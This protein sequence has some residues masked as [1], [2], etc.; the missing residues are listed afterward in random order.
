ML[1]KI[2]KIA[3]V[4]LLFFIVL[5]K[6]SNSF[7]G[8][9][10]W[11]LR[12]GQDAAKG[13]FQY[14]DSYTWGY[15]GENWVN[16]EWGGDIIFWEMYNTTGYYSLIILVALITAGA[17]FLAAK[18][19]SGKTTILGLAIAAISLKNV[20]HILVMRLAMFSVLLFTLL[21]WTLEKIPEKKYYYFWPI[22]FWVW[23][24]LHGGWTLGFITI[25]IYFFG[26]LAQTLIH[27][28]YPTIPSSSWKKKDFIKVAGAQ[29]VSL[30]MILLNP[31]GYRIFTE[32]IAYFTQNFYKSHITE[33][34]ASYVFPI[35]WPSLIISTI[36][37]LFSVLLFYKQKINLPQFLL[38]I[39]FF[40]SGFMYKRNALYIVLIGIPIII[41]TINLAWEI[42]KK[43]R[44][45]LRE[46]FYSKLMKTIL[47]IFGSFTIFF[48]LF[49]YGAKIKIY[50][51]PWEQRENLIKNL[52]PYDAV[53]FLKKETAG[54][55]YKIFNEY[56]W[57]GYMN[58]ELRE[59]PIFL[60]G[61]GT[62]TWESKENPGQ[63]M[64]QDYFAIKSDKGG[65]EKLELEKV[66]YIIIQNNNFII[67]N[68]PDKINQL[69]FGKKLNKV[70][71]PVPTQLET[72]LANNK[73]WQ[74]IY[75]DYA[76]SIWKNLT[77]R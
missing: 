15:Y 74:L 73:N 40:C 19:Y 34:V 61:R 29:I 30:L 37:L 51:N 25:N 6:I 55:Q 33:W 31:Y 7:D 72:D 53:Q 1:E 60:D 69:I 8:D 18:I 65:L 5:S 20:S 26:H 77:V 39:A 50:Q 59:Q 9:F 75:S 21:W 41:T 64:L 22:L 62:A 11:H 49:S 76:A 45:D 14:T 17:F 23:S 10:G 12:F 71:N 24:I 44:P 35:Y 28:Y 58:W 42:I 63:T 36:V 67:Y 52:M 66:D 16:H 2:I 4:I 56:S 48:L 70:F 43:Q 54:K 3:L 27:K 46:I 32:V 57:G 38:V 47:I 68:L 13:N